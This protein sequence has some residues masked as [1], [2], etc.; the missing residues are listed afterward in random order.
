MKLHI[1]VEGPS[2]EAFLKEWM[3]RFLPSHQFKTIVHRGKG[4]LSEAMDAAPDSKK[5]GLLDQLP[6]K[7][8]AYSRSLDPST[9]RVLVLIDADNEPCIDLKSRLSRCHKNNAPDLVALFRIAVEETEAFYLGDRK[10]IARAFPKAKLRRLGDYTQDSICGT[11]EKFRDVIDYPHDTEDK[12]GW[13]AQMG[14]HL[15]VKFE[16]ESNVSPS[17]QQF[18]CGILWLCGERPSRQLAKKRKSKIKRG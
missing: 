16:D 12:P 15:T 6:A 7:L 11:W 2:E 8:R 17:F 14:K 9:D 1:L 4:R 18:C 10:A 13:A 5:Q 3:P